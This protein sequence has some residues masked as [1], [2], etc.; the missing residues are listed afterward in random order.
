MFSLPSAYDDLIQIHSEEEAPQPTLSRAIGQISA[1]PAFATGITL[2]RFATLTSV[3]LVEVKMAL[4][5]TFQCVL[6]QT[7]VW[8]VRMEPIQ[9]KVHSDD[10]I[11]LSYRS[12]E[13]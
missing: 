4:R 12:G 1:D 9:T 5:L 3:T 13:R 6:N 11:C 7:R 8:R 10:W 2:I